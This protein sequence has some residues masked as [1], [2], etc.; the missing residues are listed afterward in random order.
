[1]PVKEIA[2]VSLHQ[3]KVHPSSSA[4]KGSVEAKRN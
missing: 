2:S 4:T 3:Y 1:M